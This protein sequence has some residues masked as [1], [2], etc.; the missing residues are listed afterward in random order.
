MKRVLSLFLSVLMLLSITAGMDFSALAADTYNIRVRGNCNYNLANEIL[1]LVNEE[2]AKVGAAPLTMDTGLL[3]AAM[4][5]AEETSLYFDHDRPDDSSI[6]T[7]NSNIHGENI[8]AGVKTAED[9]MDLW[10]NSATHKS[11]ILNSNFK[12]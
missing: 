5:R 6:R 7:L 2:R 1:V 3:D 8:A 10:M 4:V 11:N 9:V 12:Q